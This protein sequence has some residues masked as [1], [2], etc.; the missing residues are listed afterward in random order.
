MWQ[1]AIYVVES[2]EQEKYICFNQGWG[3]SSFPRWEFYPDEEREMKFI[4]K[5]KHPEYFL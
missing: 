4:S 2:Y 1:D 5:K 3:S